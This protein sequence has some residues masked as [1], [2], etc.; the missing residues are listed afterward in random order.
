MRAHFDN[1]QTREF[2]PIDMLS[3]SDVDQF[4][5]TRRFAKDWEDIDSARR[6]G[7]HNVL[8]YF[9]N[10]CAALSKTPNGELRRVRELTAYLDRDP[11]TSAKFHKNKNEIIWDL[12]KLRDHDRY[13][14]SRQN[15]AFEESEDEVATGNTEVWNED[16][17]NFKAGNVE[18]VLCR[19]EK[20]TALKNELINTDSMR[21]H[22]QKLSNK[23]REEI[24]KRI[25]I[26][27]K[28]R[29]AIRQTRANLLREYFSPDSIH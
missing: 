4:I 21:L 13:L 2:S 3:E 29:D 19:L 25:D 24:L 11:R 10:E 14:L 28:K 23:E 22:E 26:R 18:R 16:I 15:G 6:F 20:M 27:T 1:P 5:S 7:L 17:E 12:E 9:E 8:P